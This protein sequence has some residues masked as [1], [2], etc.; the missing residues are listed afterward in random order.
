MSEWKRAREGKRG[1]RG[2]KLASDIRILCMRKIELLSTIRGFNL[3]SDSLELSDK[4]AVLFPLGE[5][6]SYRKLG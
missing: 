5:M 2:R 4:Q 6:H 1:D 3:P